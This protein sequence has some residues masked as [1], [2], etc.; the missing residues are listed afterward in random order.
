LADLAVTATLLVIV[1]DMTLRDVTIIAFL[2]I[3]LGVTPAQNAQDKKTESRTVVNPPGL[4]FVLK[5]KEDQKNVY[6]LGQIIEIEEDYSSNIPGRYLLLQN[7]QKVEGGAPSN[8][9][10]V[11][12]V[13]VI[14]RV[15]H[16]GWVSAAAILISSC[17][18]VGGGGA[19]FC[20]DCDGVYKLGRD[21]LHFSYPLNYRFSITAPG[22]YTIQARASNVVDAENASKAL[23]VISTPLNIEIIQDDNWSHQ[24]LRKALERFEQ[25][26]LKY[27]HSGW[28]SKNPRPDEVGEQM[29]TTLELEQSMEVIRYLDTEESLREAVRLFDG[30]PRI[31]TYENMFLKA[32][33][34]SS[35]RDLAVSLLAHR[36]VDDDFGPSV[37]LID[38]LTGMTIQSEQPIVFERE[39]QSSQQ[40]LSPRTLEIL[41][42]YVLA[43]GHSLPSKHHDVRDMAVATFEHYANE[44]NCTGEPLIQKELANQILLEAR[45]N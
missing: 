44:K 25:A 11:P 18:G 43:L 23:Q 9:T 19:G 28:D 12:D 7:P 17:G 16:T 15:R 4:S 24:Q 35:H 40:Q 41:R 33:L 14:D 30:S 6:H 45:S 32:I 27:I 36:M 38:I 21:P 5:P 22:H 10:I 42:G 37:D 1:S 2:G 8:L 20:A 13:S 34:E 39:D 31:A 29:E 3:W 26:H